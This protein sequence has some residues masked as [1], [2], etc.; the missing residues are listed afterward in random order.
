MH[1]K[2]VVDIEGKGVVTS[3]EKEKRRAENHSASLLFYS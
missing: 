3:K 1:G 2:G